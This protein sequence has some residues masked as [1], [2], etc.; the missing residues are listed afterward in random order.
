M[1]CMHTCLLDDYQISVSTG[2]RF[3]ES[4]SRILA[5]GREGVVEFP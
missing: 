2:I 4:F 3:I 5:A 1:K